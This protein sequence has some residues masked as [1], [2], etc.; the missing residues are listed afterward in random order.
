MG[1]ALD[2]PN[3]DE[4][5]VQVNGLDVIIGE[6]VKGFAEGS[7]VDYTKSSYGEGFTI[8]NVNSGC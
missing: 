2:E 8:R 6:K 4:V 7:L 1:L 5:L 3:D